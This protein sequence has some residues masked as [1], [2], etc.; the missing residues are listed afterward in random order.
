MP[1]TDREIWTVANLY[2][3]VLG[4][5]ARARAQE[6]AAALEVEGDAE[7]QAIWVLVDRAIEEMQ[8]LGFLH[9]PSW[10]T[11]HNG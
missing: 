2:V 10:K 1:I 6:R 3:M 11:S 5:D 7:G 9:S 8:W 4:R